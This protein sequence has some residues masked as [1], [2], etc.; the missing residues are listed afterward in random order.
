MRR[1]VRIR[2]MQ[3]TLGD[4]RGRPLADALSSP[5]RHLAGDGPLASARRAAG[6]AFFR[7]TRSLCWTGLPRE[8][9]RGPRHAREWIFPSSSLLLLLVVA[10]LI[11]DGARAGRAVESPASAAP[12][13]R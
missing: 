13:G 9:R 12:P 4:R 7:A 3:K 11:A 1:S 10:A 5:S 6:P 8:P 2:M